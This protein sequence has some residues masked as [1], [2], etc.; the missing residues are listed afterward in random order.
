MIIARINMK[1]I[2]KLVV[3]SLAFLGKQ[4]LASEG[5]FEY[6]EHGAD[7]TGTCATVSYFIIIISFLLLSLTIF[8]R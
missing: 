3:F 5:V 4:T 6:L 1:N 7:W 2:A 8:K